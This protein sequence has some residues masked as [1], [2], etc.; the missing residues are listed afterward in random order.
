MILILAQVTPAAPP[1]IDLSPLFTS[2][3]E[4]A[5]QMMPLAMTMGAFWLAIQCVS[6]YFFTDTDR[7]YDMSTHTNRK[8]DKMTGKTFFETLFSL[9]PSTEEGVSLVDE[10][11]AYIEKHKRRL[12]LAELRREAALEY[13]LET[14]SSRE[15]ES[16]E[17]VD[18][19]PPLPVADALDED[20]MIL[21]A[22]GVDFAES[23]AYYDLTDKRDID[24]YGEED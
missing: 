21:S 18:T 23:R 10:D 15:E 7:V 13:E 20:D 22:S 8:I 5:L 3:W 14:S 17:Y 12:H 24:L 19:P 16:E 2:L 6:W 11:E 1:R 4:M 9:P